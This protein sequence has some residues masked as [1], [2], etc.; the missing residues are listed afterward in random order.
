MFVK[1]II[2]RPGL[3]ELGFLLS[4]NFNRPA[5]ADVFFPHFFAL[6]FIG[7]ANH[8]FGVATYYG[9]SNPTVVIAR[10]KIEVVL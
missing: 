8:C 7:G 2:S 6:P 9:Q 3:K 1:P 5:T 4:R 10:R